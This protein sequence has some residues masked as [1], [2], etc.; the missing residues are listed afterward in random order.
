MPTTPAGGEDA[1]L[2]T[3]WAGSIYGMKTRRGLVELAHQNEKGEHTWRTQ[4]RIEEARAFALSVL[5]AAEAAESDSVV[6]MFFM[7][8]LGLELPQAAQVL[9]DFRQ[10]REGLS[11]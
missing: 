10:L 11:Q 7:T 6:V 8:R 3:L 5:E 4:L 9:N 2:E 1:R